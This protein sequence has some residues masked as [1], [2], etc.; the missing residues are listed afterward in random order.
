[1][2]FFRSL[3]VLAQMVLHQ[4]AQDGFLGVCA[5]NVLGKVGHANYGL[6]LGEATV[7]ADS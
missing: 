2:L 7:E 1:M 3:Q 6:F 5:C 4:S